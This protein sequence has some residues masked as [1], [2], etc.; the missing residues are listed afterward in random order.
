MQHATCLGFTSCELALKT[1]ETMHQ[2]G[3]LP[4]FGHDLAVAAL[5][6]LEAVDEAR[7]QSFTVLLDPES[8]TAIHA[9]TNLVQ[10]PY[11]R[12]CISQ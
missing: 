9:F 8:H 10:N 1:H 3:S 2:D 11:P 7:A 4:L 6:T 5:T 12:A